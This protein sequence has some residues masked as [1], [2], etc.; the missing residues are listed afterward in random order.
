MTPSGMVSVS[1]EC[2]TDPSGFFTSMAPDSRIGRVH[3]A[4][5]DTWSSHSG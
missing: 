4:A 3:A 1:I 5:A 2:M